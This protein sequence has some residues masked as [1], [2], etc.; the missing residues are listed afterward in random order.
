MVELISSGLIVMGGTR[1]VNSA[2]LYSSM[3]RS[4]IL[5]QLAL[6]SRGMVCDSLHKLT[7][8]GTVA[9]T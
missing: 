6:V 2:V 3:H 5:W 8:R 1:V 9:A 7:V 4:R